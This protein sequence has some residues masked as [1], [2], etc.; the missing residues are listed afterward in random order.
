MR[1]TDWSLINPK[2]CQFCGVF[3]WHRNNEKLSQFKRRRF[4]SNSC[5][6]AGL[7]KFN[8]GKKA[9]NNKQV[10]ITCKQCNGTKSVAPAFSNKQFCNR[11]CMAKWMSENCRGENHWNWKGGITEIAS[12]NVLYPGYKEWRKEVFKRD[13][14]KCVKCGCNKSGELEAHHIKPRSEFKELILDISNGLTVC[15]KCHKN[16]HYGKPKGGFF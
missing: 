3:F 1:K 15:K 2:E 4:C 8:T 6:L 13:G 7:F 5:K 10:I 14:Y 12:R 11:K 9:H 16:I